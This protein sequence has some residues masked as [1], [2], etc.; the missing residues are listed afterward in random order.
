MTTSETVNENSASE[1]VEAPAAE[2]DAAQVVAWLQ[3]HPDFFATQ[4]D[5]LADMIIPHETGGAVSL[6][7]R[8][9]SILR[10]RNVELRERLHKL[11]DIARENDN[12]FTRMRGQLLDLLE[13]RSVAELSDRLVDGLRVRFQSEY[14]TLS[15]FDV[16]NIDIGSAQALSLSSAEE[17]V[18]SIIH[19]QRAVAGHLTD[20]Q[21]RFL[22]RDLA[23]SVASSVVVPLHAGRPIGLLAIGSSR[24]DHFVEDMDTLF[25]GHLGDV[26][27]RLLKPYLAHGAS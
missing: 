24:P 17:A 12:L 14:V 7:E 4:S 20:D 6:L 5:L 23:V 10:T 2:L 16:D 3:R 15:L 26:L 13:A 8:Q 11:L 25:V 1:A 9:L 18:S 21:V 19:G 27:T 22:F